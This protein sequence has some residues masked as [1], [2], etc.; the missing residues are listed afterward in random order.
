MDTLK[1]NVEDATTGLSA[2]AMNTHLTNLGS[3]VGVDPATGAKT[4]SD[5][6]ESM[7]T[8]KAAVEDPSTGLASRAGITE[9]TNLQT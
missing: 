6:A 9:F 1:T 8:L 4:A 7:D 2:R 3:T 5:R